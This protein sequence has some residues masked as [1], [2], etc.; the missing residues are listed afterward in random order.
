MIVQSE[1]TGAITRLWLIDPGS[2]EPVTY[3]KGR[4]ARR[5]VHA[6][7]WY[8][9]VVYRDVGLAAPGDAVFGTEVMHRRPRDAFWRQG[10]FDPKREPP[11]YQTYCYAAHLDP[12]TGAL[13]DYWQQQHPGAPP[14]IARKPEPDQIAHDTLLALYHKGAPPPGVYLLDQLL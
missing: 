2:A 10:R 3:G 7:A 13:V 1:D 12:A 5:A 4:N 9:N 8:L 6:R 11:G 14:I